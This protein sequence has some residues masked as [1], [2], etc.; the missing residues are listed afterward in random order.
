MPIKRSGSQ[1]Q[2]VIETLTGMFPMKTVLIM[3]TFSQTAGMLVI[4]VLLI[5][6]DTKCGRIATHYISYF[7]KQLV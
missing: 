4:P 2:V 3:K 6:L 5:L 1:I 7:T